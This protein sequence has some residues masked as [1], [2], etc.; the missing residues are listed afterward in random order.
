MAGQAPVET[1]QSRVDE[2]S[3]LD[4]LLVVVSNL[5]TLIS[6]PLGAALIAFGITFLIPPTYTATTRILPPTQQQ[7]AS[8]ILATQ[9]GSLAGLLGG[10]PSI[11]NPSDQF[12]ALLKSRTVFDGVVKRFDLK[13]AYD[14]QY[15]EDVR[16]ELDKRTRISAGVR[17]GII[18]ID[19]EDRD[20]KR[21]AD[22]ANAFVEELRELSNALAITEASQRRLFFEMQLNQ[23]R[24]ELTK[25]EF[26]LRSSGVSEATLRTLPQSTLELLARLKAQITAQEIKLASMRTFMTDSNPDLR[27]AIQE[28]GALR[29]E[30]AKAEQSNAVKAIGNGAE[31]ISKYREFKYQEA[32]FELLAKQHELAR[33]DEAREGSL[34]QVVDIAQP[35][36]KRSGP[37][38]FL[39]AGL[40]AVVTVFLYVLFMLLRQ[41]ISYSGEDPTSR[42]KIDRL[43]S[44]LVRLFLWK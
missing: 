42:P 1:Y 20:A 25:S 13:R 36:E 12:V 29:L 10:A 41:A 17:D 7:T 34:I 9:L 21:A 24:R 40:T 28:L 4:L 31:Y 38:R 2:V 43:K 6:L 22:M 44:G 8:S 5:R 33:L 37:R 14:V 35:P 32:L 39:I 19:V 23:A 15:A 30:L 16:K 11:K 27:L 26:A 3:L 18:T